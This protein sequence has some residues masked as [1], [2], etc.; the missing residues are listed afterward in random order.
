MEL[1]ETIDKIKTK[2][3][4]VGSL[5]ENFGSLKQKK[6]ITDGKLKELNPFID[7]RERLHISGHFKQEQYHMKAS[8]K[9]SYPTNTTQAHL[10]RGTHNHGYMRTEF[11]LSTLRQNYYFVKKDHKQVLLL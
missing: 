7:D 10:L 9:I 5:T 1:S 8:I 3:Y 2:D 6:P 4:L 11:V